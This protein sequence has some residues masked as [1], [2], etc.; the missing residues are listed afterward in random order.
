M[1]SFPFQLGQTPTQ[2]GVMFFLNSGVYALL[3]PAVG[4]VGDKTVRSDNNKVKRNE[5]V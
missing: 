2:I 3:S 1:N 4:C 5:R